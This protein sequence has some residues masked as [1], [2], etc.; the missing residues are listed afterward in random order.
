MTTDKAI[1]QKAAEVIQ[2]CGK[3]YDPWQYASFQM[4]KAYYRGEDTQAIVWA[5]VANVVKER[6]EAG[7]VTAALAR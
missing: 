6:L 2:K 7:P 1:Q 5:R 4:S 3:R